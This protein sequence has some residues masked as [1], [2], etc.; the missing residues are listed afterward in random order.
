MFGFVQL[1]GRWPLIRHLCAI[2]ASHVSVWYAYIFHVVNKVERLWFNFILVTCD[3]IYS[4]V[5]QV[6]TSSIYTCGTYCFRIYSAD[7]MI[8]P[9]WMGSS[10][11]KISFYLIITG[12]KSWPSLN[13]LKLSW[14][15]TESAI[16]FAGSHVF[17][18]VISLM[19]FFKFSPLT[20]HLHKFSSHPNSLLNST[21]ED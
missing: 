17:L 20:P 21:A 19:P 4:T 3:R 15:W 2:L 8:G 10:L 18:V 6:S 1:F 5:H 12:S 16:E 14:W 7:M 9:L 13:Q 11:W